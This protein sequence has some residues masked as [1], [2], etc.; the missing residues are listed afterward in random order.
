MEPS[1]PPTA[2][3]PEQAATDLDDP[4]G[5]PVQSTRS[6]HAARTL[7]LAGYVSGISMATLFGVT[8]P[9]PPWTAL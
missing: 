3:S 8:T 1:H 7:A 9:T 5:A 2:P 4:I 6:Q